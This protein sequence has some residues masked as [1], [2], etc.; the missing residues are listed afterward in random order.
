MSDS[1]VRYY[2]KNALKIQTLYFITVAFSFYENK[3]IV[4][5]STSSLI[6][7]VSGLDIYQE[8]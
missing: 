3:A 4:D 1:K 7:V 2:N 5:Y 6:I 8:L